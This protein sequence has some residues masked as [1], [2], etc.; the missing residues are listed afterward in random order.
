MNLF[1]PS[2]S[3]S[4][5]II[6]LTNIAVL[7]CLLVSTFAQ[8]DEDENESELDDEQSATTVKAETLIMSSSPSLWTSYL[9]FCEFI[10]PYGAILCF[11]APLPTVRQIVSNKTVGNLPLLPY[12]SMIANCFVWV[13]YG[14]L[15]NVPS[16]WMSNSVG[17]ICG[18]YYSIMFTKYC[19]PSRTICREL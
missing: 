17:V 1:L 2:S 12:S 18:T 6:S 16:V 19:N 9:N 14:L 7:L 11:L 8:E 4:Q 13:T 15:K 5:R 10:A 3:Q